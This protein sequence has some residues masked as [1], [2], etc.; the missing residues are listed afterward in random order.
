MLWALSR[1][2]NLFHTTDLRAQQQQRQCLSPART[3]KKLDAFTERCPLLGWLDPTATHRSE[4][5]LERP[6][7]PT[8]QLLSHA[9][10]RCYTASNTQ[11]SSRQKRGVCTA[12]AAATLPKISSENTFGFVLVETRGIFSDFHFFQFWLFGAIFFVLLILFIF[13]NF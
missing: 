9:G 12:P 5:P 2:K 13:V 4:D 11:A 8:I 1:N 7:I 6:S 3:L 10:V